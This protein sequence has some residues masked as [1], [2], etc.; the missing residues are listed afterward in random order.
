MR[1]SGANPTAA[2]LGVLRITDELTDPIRQGAI[3]FLA[4]MQIDEGGMRANTRIPIAD[5]LSSF[6]VA[7]SLS[8]LGGLD[9]IDTEAL[10]RFA[11]S[12][13]QPSGGFL[14][15]DWDEATDVEY[16]FYGLGLLGL[17]A[18]RRAEV[19]EERQTGKNH[20]NPET[21]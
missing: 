18:A 9:R 13:Q 12:L 15:A 17:L 3:C 21:D 14:A 1:R 2:A 5:L 6:T 20:F 7:L 8:D 4:E 11:E 19:D 10:R 16:T